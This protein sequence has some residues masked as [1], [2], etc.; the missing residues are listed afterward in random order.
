LIT[1]TCIYFLLQK[2]N[3]KNNAIYFYL[4]NPPYFVVVWLLHGK[5][6]KDVYLQESDGERVES[7]DSVW[8]YQH[9]TAYKFL[10]QTLFFLKNTD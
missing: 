10:A 6:E 4:L 2:G 3:T 9:S 7:K 5:G 1:A 8:A